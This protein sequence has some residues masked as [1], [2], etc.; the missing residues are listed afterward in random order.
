MITNDYYIRDIMTYKV[1]SLMTSTSRKFELT[2]SRFFGNTHR[3]SDWDFF[4]EYSDSV[5][6]WLKAWGFHRL[7]ANLVKDLMT[8]YPGD[9][10]IV[11]VWQKHNVQVQLVINFKI[12]HYAQ[13]L[14]SVE[15]ARKWYLA[16]QKEGRKEW[17]V[18]A[19]R[20]ANR[21]LREE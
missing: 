8:L 2:G 11:D 14:L 19:L 5:V 7:E 4:T 15:P 16:A 21:I 20:S 17:W 9:P 13:M 12:K 18:W 1:I 6:D 3:F 10:N